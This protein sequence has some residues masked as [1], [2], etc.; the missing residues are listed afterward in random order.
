M[1]ICKTEPKKEEVKPSDVAIVKEVPEPVLR[2]ILN[3][4]T[5]DEDK[6]L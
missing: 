2:Q 6:K 3:T 1:I 4:E 5:K